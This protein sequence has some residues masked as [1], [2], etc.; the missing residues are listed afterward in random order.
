MPFTIC[1]QAAGTACGCMNAPATLCT[2][3]AHFEM[4]PLSGTGFEV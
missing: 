2:L 4:H 1:E 3:R